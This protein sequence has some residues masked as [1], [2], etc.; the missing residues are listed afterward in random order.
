MLSSFDYIV[1]AINEIANEAE[2]EEDLPPTRRKKE[3]WNGDAEFSKGNEAYFKSARQF[4]DTP[5]LS[6]AVVETVYR[7]PNA[8][9]TVTSPTSGNIVSLPTAIG[10]HS[11]DS[12]DEYET[13][14]CFLHRL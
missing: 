5:S 4:Y 6:S 14:V 12:M 8:K 11:M 1:D 13:A 7:K 10:Y 9:Q 2:I 3:R